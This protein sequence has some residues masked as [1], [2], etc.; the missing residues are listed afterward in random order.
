[1]SENKHQ[2]KQILTSRLKHSNLTPLQMR[3]AGILLY[4][5]GLQNALDFIAG[6]ERSNLGLCIGKNLTCPNKPQP[7]ETT[8]EVCI[9]ENS[10]QR[11]LR[12]QGQNRLKP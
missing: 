3:M 7:G 11:E 10:R 2:Q 12:N 8:C 9:E 4:H 5:N 1:M 6:L